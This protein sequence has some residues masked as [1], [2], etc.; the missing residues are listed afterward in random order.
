RGKDPVA[1]LW[2]AGDGRLLSEVMTHSSWVDVCHFTPNGQ[3]LVTASRDATLKYWG[4][5][6]LVSG[7]R[8]PEYSH[9]LPA[10]VMN[11]RLS[12]DGRRIALILEDQSVRLASMETSGG[13]ITLVHRGVVFDADFDRR[14]ERLVTGSSRGG[15]RLWDVRT[16]QPISETFRDPGTVWLARFHP[17]DTSVL[18]AGDGGTARIRSLPRVSIPAPPWLPDFA[19]TQV[20]LR[21]DTLEGFTQEG[22]LTWEQ[23]DA[24][25]R[26]RA[27]WGT[28]PDLR[29]LGTLE[30]LG[31]GTGNSM[32]E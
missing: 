4:V 1:S 17:D 10:G 20:S 16:G 27:G 26:G 9:W 24:R 7:I 18:T 31:P 15:A 14:G 21:G 8:D 6:A 23:L 32:P 11:M 2:D 5:E 30:D 3:W 19:E 12:G 28:L 29:R 22:L 13:V 25:W